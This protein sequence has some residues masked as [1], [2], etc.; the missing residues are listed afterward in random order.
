[1]IRQLLFKPETVMERKTVINLQD[2]FTD[3]GYVNHVPE[4]PMQDSVGCDNNRT[5][6]ISQVSDKMPEK[7]FI[8]NSIYK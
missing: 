1:M 5:S 4:C 7:C 3:T 6:A 2:I 8:T